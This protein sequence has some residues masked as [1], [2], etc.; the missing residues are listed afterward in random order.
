MTNRGQLCGPGSIWLMNGLFAG[1]QMLLGMVYIK[2]SGGEKGDSPDLA[3][4]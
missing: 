2:R 4:T 1:S 3:R